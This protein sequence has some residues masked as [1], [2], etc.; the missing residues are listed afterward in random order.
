M[1]YAVSFVIPD[2]DGE[3]FLIVKRPE[4][5]ADLPGYWGLPATSVTEQERYEAAVERAGR[6]KLGVNLEITGFMG[7]GNIERDDEL[8]HME[9]LETG[10]MI[11]TPSVP[12]SGDGTQYTDWRWGTATDLKD[13]ARNGSL[14]CNL[15]L[16]IRGDR[17]PASLF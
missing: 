12:Q 14:C 6:E 11:G 1:K 2:E 8:L 17:A 4:D 5:D 9:L 3:R 16:A 15:Y 10:I 13:A 7:R